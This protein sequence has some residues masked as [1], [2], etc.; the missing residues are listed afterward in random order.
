MIL[1]TAAAA[2]GTIAIVGGATLPASMGGWLAIGAI[3]L[4]STAIA[5]AAFLS[6]VKRIG[7]SQASIISTL[8]PIITLT[9]GV[10]VLGEKASSSQLLGG[11][12]V[13]FA[14]ILL[15]QRPTPSTRI[16]EDAEYQT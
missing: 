11:A 13:L 9:I 5:I 16:E 1:A 10:S 8:E 15:A 14:V 3:A 2:N 6:G 4:F 12:M 7:A